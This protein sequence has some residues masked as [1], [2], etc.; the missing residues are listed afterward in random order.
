MNLKLSIICTE[1]SNG[2]Y[3]AIC[4]DIKGC[5]TQGDTLDQ[6]IRQLKDLM[7]ATIRE[8]LHSEELAE[9]AQAKSKIFS[10]IEIAV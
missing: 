9:L 8:D 4:P 2:A 3:V 1:Q 7:M 10:E 6:A 5:F